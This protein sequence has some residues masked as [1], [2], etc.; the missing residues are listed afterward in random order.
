MKLE[1]EYKAVSRIV[2][3]I[4][5]LVNPLQAMSL[6]K[7]KPLARREK[8]NGKVVL[9]S[10]EPE[11]SIDSPLARVE[12]SWKGGERGQQHSSYHR[13]RRLPGGTPV[14]PL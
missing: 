8:R 10:A 7:L 14:F 9:L 4:Y 12:N 1:P 5:N 11:C 3:L 2:Q 6:V 13:S